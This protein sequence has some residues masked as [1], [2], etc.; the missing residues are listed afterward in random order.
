MKKTVQIA[1]DGPAGAGKSTVAKI[2][3]QELGYI[4][5]DTGAMYRALTYKIIKE[6]LDLTDISLLKELAEK[7]NITF[8][9][10]QGFANQL[11]YCDGEDVTQLI[12]SPGVNKLVSKVA[13]IP[14]IREIMVLKQR[15]LSLTANVIM[16]GRDI[17]TVVLPDAKYKFFLTASLQERANRRLKELKEKGYNV[18]YAGVLDDIAQRDLMDSTRDVAPLKPARDAVII[19]TSNMSLNEVVSKIKKIVLEG[20]NRAL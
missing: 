18:Q 14:E 11:V 2:L 9:N 17:G 1:I 4:Y 19:D 10:G 5:I 7:T 20:E 8:D 6:K 15:N 12:R 3:A 13:S 16:D